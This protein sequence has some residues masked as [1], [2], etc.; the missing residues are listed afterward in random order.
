MVR[1]PYCLKWQF[2]NVIAKTYMPVMYTTTFNNAIMQQCTQIKM[3]NFSINIA[4]FF[5]YPMFVT[6]L[7]KTCVKNLMMNG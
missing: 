2:K 4:F 3:T 6:I 7:L 1:L 5:K